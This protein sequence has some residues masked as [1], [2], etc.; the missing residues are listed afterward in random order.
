MSSTD[1]MSFITKMDSDDLRDLLTKNGIDDADADY[2]STLLS[3]S[4]N[5]ESAGLGLS[6]HEKTRGIFD[7]AIRHTTDDGATIGFKDMISNNFEGS[8]FPYGRAQAGA[9]TLEKMGLKSDE[10]RKVSRAKIKEE[11]DA[12]ELADEITPAQAVREL[13]RYDDTILELQGKPLANFNPFGKGAQALRT[14][15]NMN[16]ARYLGQTFWTMSAELGST[17]W[18]TGMVH[19]IKSGPM[20][21]QLRKQFLSGKFDDELMQE[22]YTHLGLMGDMNRGI[23]FSKYEHDF[24]NVTSGG[25]GSKMDKLEEVS[26]KFR[27]AAL[28]IGGI[29]PLTAYFEAAT[30][31]GLITKMLKSA[32]GKRI[33]KGFET[34][35]GEMGFT[36]SLRKDIFEQML[37]HTKT[38]ESKIFGKGLKKINLEE[39]D[40]EIRD[41][42]IIGVKRHTNTIVQRSTMGDKVGVMVGDKLMQNTWQGKLG[43]EMKGYVVNAWSKQLGRALTRRDLYSLGMLTTQMSLG[44]M[45]YMAQTYTNYPNDPKKRA[46]LLTPERI[47]KATFSRSSMASWMPQLIDTGAQTGLYE[48]QF[49]HARSSGLGSGLV[50]GMPVIDLLDTASSAF[51]LPAAALGI[52]D[53]KP[54]ELKNAFRVLPLH[55]AMGARALMESVVGSYK[56]GRAE[57][58]MRGY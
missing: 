31:S 5:S 56:D 38:T 10:A 7:Y 33:P 36:G 18:N 28:M 11:L 45:A 20:M 32:H 30:S 53:V 19:M 35:L 15:K 46:E 16:I 9:N 39:W 24:A 49:S 26:E 22:I 52:G 55:N 17:V 43:L 47:A 3:K 37:K 4:D 40:P 50:A 1:E 21:G 29:K 25:I 12:A 57:D 6:K 44:A 14:A 13:D 27:E 8:W 58:R 41:A 23:G 51:K 34:T 42:F 54:G 2:I 48:K